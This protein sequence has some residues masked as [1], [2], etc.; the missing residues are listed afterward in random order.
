MD[1]L[2]REYSLKERQDVLFHFYGYRTLSLSSSSPSPPTLDLLNLRESDI[3]QLSLFGSIIRAL[4]L[5]SE[6]STWLATLPASSAKHDGLRE[7]FLRHVMLYNRTQHPKDRLYV[8]GLSA[9]DRAFLECLDAEGGEIETGEG[10]G[11]GKGELNWVSDGCV[12]YGGERVTKVK[13]VED[14]EK[15]SEEVEIVRLEDDGARLQEAK[16]D[17]IKRLKELKIED[18]EKVEMERFGEL[19][20]AGF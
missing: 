12:G 7:R 15:E 4:D 13:E 10:K 1:F 9:R 5:R 6:L 16:I 17:F 3:S 20:G 18:G 2:L 11:K 8:L 19:L 14:G